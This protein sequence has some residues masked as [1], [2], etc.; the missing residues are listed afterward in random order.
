MALS[1]QTHTV[2]LDPL[3]AVNRAFSKQSPHYDQEDSTNP[4][5]ADMR[6]QVYAHVH[7][8]IKP[9]SSILELNAGTGIDAL[10]FASSGYAVHATDLSDGMIR[11]IRKK[12]ESSSL[13]DRFTCQQLS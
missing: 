6:R 3:D 13:G 2:T 5:L 8:L 10:H 1:Q 4:V 12:I 7:R 9:G 11:E